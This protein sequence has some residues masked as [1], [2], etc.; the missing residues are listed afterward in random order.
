MDAGDFP[1]DTGVEL[2]LA[3]VL[4]RWERRLDAAVAA[5]EALPAGERRR[6]Q[7]ELD[8]AGE[9]DEWV[10]VLWS[11]WV[12]AGPADQALLGD[13]VAFLLPVLRA[14]RRDGRLGPGGGEG[15]AA[16]RHLLDALERMERILHP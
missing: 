15:A 13:D 3:E 8:E 6:R 4:G 12:H 16:S 10:R 2:R 14:A 7:E 1:V 9:S 11:W 5:W